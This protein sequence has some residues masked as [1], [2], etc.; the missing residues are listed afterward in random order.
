MAFLDHEGVEHRR[1]VVCGESRSGATRPCATI[2]CGGATQELT[3][4]GARA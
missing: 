3:A 1:V 4:S 2:W